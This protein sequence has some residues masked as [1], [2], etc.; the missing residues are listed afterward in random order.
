VITDPWGRGNGLRAS[1]EQAL[2][3]VS[4]DYG[5]VHVTVERPRRTTQ[6]TRDSPSLSAWAHGHKF[7]FSGSKHVQRFD[8][9]QHKRNCPGSC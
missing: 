9:V 4:V 8:A 6:E 1:A 7:G 3:K 2:G 5:N